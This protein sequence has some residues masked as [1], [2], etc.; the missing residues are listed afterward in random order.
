MPQH[1]W[2]MRR[3]KIKGRTSCGTLYGSDA[4]EHLIG[5][6]GNDHLFGGAGDDIL[7]GNIGDDQLTGGPGAD[8]F[9]IGE[10]HDRIT[11]FNPLEGDQIVYSTVRE[12]LSLPV[13]E[14]TLL[15]TTSDDIYTHIEGVKPERVALHSQQRLKPKFKV[16]FQNGL[17]IKPESAETKFHQQLGMMQREPLPKRR[18]MM[19]PQKQEV[20]S[21]VYMYNCIA[22]LDLLFL[23]NE[24]IVDL[25]VNLPICTLDQ[26]DQCPRYES[27]SP[28]DHW[29]ELRSGMVK[30]LGLE[31]GDQAKI[32]PL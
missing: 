22:P 11:D 2:S 17:S 16:I 13:S 20:N 24:T 30:K 29:L 28:F 6:R 10:G 4:H 25:S 15:M 32:I 1:P 3:Q 5:K 19:F 7:I 14:G 18:G 23:R 27:I 26:P 31:I 21:S 9:V 8:F 12:I